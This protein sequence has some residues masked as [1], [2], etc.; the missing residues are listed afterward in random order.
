MLILCYYL[1]FKGVIELFSLLNCDTVNIKRVTGYDSYGNA[2]FSSIDKIKCKIEYKF[3]RIVNR[4]G[5]ETVSS[6]T[7]RTVEPL[8]YKDQIEI[9]G[10]FRDLLEVQP[11]TDFGGKTVYW[12]GWF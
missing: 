6:G 12:I 10:E 5:V 2:D 4:N 7:V 1:T 11:Q 8:N 3:K 9:N